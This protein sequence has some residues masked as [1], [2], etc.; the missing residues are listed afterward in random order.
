MKRASWL[1]MAFAS[2]AALPS[3]AIAQSAPSLSGQKA[4]DVASRQARSVKD[5]VLTST[6]MPAVRIEFDKGFKYVDGHNFIV[7]CAGY[8]T[9][10]R[11]VLGG[12]GCAAPFACKTL[13]S[14][15]ILVAY[16]ADGCSPVD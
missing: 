10:E 9:H 4:T 7:L 13:V 3:P 8:S 6:E 2:L 5:Q 16:Y 12:D 14:R 11:F 1:S 15:K